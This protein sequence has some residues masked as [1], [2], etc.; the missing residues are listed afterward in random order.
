MASLIFIGEYKMSTF[1][2][3]ASKIKQPA[4]IWWL[5]STIMMT[6]EAEAE[7]SQVTYQSKQHNEYPSL[8]S[9]NIYIQF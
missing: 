3:I 4:G 9:I 6:W 1:I 5:V 2:S 8:P 7:K